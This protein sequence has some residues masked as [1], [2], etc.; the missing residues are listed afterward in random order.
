MS[1]KDDS[2]Y[3]C[4]F[5]ALQSEGID[6]DWSDSEEE[7]KI[8]ELITELKQKSDKDN[9]NYICRKHLSLA[10]SFKMST[11]SR[12]PRNF[13][14]TYS[15]NDLRPQ[16]RTYRPREYRPREY[17]HNIKT[18][19]SK[20]PRSKSEERLSQIDERKSTKE[21]LFSRHNSEKMKD[22]K[23]TKGSSSSSVIEYENCM[24]CSCQ[25]YHKHKV[26]QA[27][28]CPELN[29]DETLS[30]LEK[31]LKLSED[32]NEFNEKHLNICNTFWYPALS[33]C[34]YTN[35]DKKLE[36]ASLW[37][38]GVALRDI[39]R[40]GVQNTALRVALEEMTVMSLVCGPVE[41]VQSLVDLGLV[42]LQSILEDGAGLL[43]YACLFRQPTL[44]S[45]LTGIGIPADSKDKN[46]DF[47]DQCCFCPQLRKQLPQKYLHQQGVHLATR[48]LSLQPSIQDKDAIFKMATSPRRLYDLQKKLQMF[49]FNVNTECDSSGNFLIH[50]AVAGGICQLPL[51]MSLVRLQNADI[52]LCNSSGMTPLMIAAMEGSTILC[53]VLMCIFG[54]DPNKS[55][56]HTGKYALHYAVANK[57]VNIISCLL[58][59]G[60]D[61]N[62]ED[63][64]G[65][66]PDDQGHRYDNMFDCLDIISTARKQRIE[67]LANIVKEGNL[68]IKELWETDLVIT[69]DD[70]LTLL[71]IAARANSV[72]NL[73]ILLQVCKEKVID[74]QYFEPSYYSGS[75]DIC[76]GMTALSMAARMGHADIVYTLMKEGARCSI[77]DINGMTALQLAV[78]YNHEECVE[79]LLGFFPEAYTGIFAAMNVCKKTSIHTKLDKAWHRRQDEI[80]SSSMLEC[81]L[82]G[83]AEELYCVIEDGDKIDMKTG[84]GSW[85]LYLAVEN[86]H[87]DVVKLLCERG[88]DIRKKRSPSGFTVLHA[89]AKIGHADIMDFLLD[90]CRPLGHA[91]TV[92]KYSHYHR[93]LDI[94][95]TDSDGKTALQLAAEKGYMR[96][97][98]SL[99]LHGATTALLDSTGQLFTLSEYGGVW[100]EIESSRQRHANHVFNFITQ[101]SK[102]SFLALVKIWLP[103][104][105]HNLRDKNGDT[106]LMVAS[107]YGREEILQFLL[108]SA[109]YPQDTDQD[110]DCISMLSDADSGVLDT[111]TGYY[112][113]PSSY[114]DGKAINL[115]LYFRMEPETVTSRLENLLNDVEKPKGL[116]IYHDGLVS[117]VC[118]LNFIDGCNVIHRALQGGDNPKIIKAL[119][120]AD[121]TCIN[122]QSMEGLTP[123]HLACELKRKKSLDVL[124]ATEG[125]DLNL[126]TLDGKL[127][128]EM[129]SS[130]AIIKIV[131]NARKG[132]PV[133]PRQYVNHMEDSSM[134]GSFTDY[135]VMS[136]PSTQ[137]ASTVN[138][139]KVQMRF[140][141]MKRQRK[142]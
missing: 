134:A 142:D 118:A 30:T 41:L 43:H 116:S 80:V 13:S 89:A 81:C 132:L 44:V 58:R 49:E 128:E 53:E 60:A 16:G 20:R 100:N 31:T 109:V 136:P 108:Q 9:V 71:M 117:H 10:N 46:G 111:T 99:L 86:G 92:S 126:L 69:D 1:K 14:Q 110:D 7:F 101:K 37:Q 115:D 82:Y 106:P 56:V 94:N 90:L 5:C 57:H 138:F 70:D 123:L 24:D 107:K 25:G 139:E 78:H 21:Q 40:D 87:L 4:K 102:K 33:M 77:K 51:I 66:R 6:V 120:M 74:A 68:D 124:V 75:E 18:M 47:P 8:G 133:R 131:Q 140:E 119:L 72:V 79:I 39:L 127:A 76:T 45:W 55:N 67:R 19:D 54:A 141:A 35:G 122:M 130:K 85:P 38:R 17:R 42:R 28:F 73:K 32:L 93:G 11:R 103:G 84:N 2:D 97:V 27:E 34:D 12:S 113:P 114:R 36:F 91:P 15:A 3:Y 29:N 62:R 22:K 61:F 95:A 137:R 96:V 83:K 52:E 88:A 48:V 64:N 65:C 23:F 98:K 50:T 105:D 59:R 26:S 129:T 63:Y 125:I 112:K 121:S 104:F 135:N